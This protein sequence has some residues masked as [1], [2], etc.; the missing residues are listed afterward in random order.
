MTFFRRLLSEDGWSK[1][2]FGPLAIAVGLGAGA[3]VY[4]VANPPTP[5]PPPPPAGSA[6]I[7]VDTS[8]GTC[9]KVTV[10]IDYPN[11]GTEC[12]SLA[13]AYAVAGAG[14]TIGL[15]AGTYSGTTLAYRS[16]LANGSCDPYGEWGA[17]SPTSCV[18][19]VP[20]GGTVIFTGTVTIKGSGIWIDGPLTGSPND[21]SARTYSIV[22]D[23]SADV[24]VSDPMNTGEILTLGD[25]LGH[26]V[27]HVTIQGVHSHNYEI[28][29]SNHVLYT[30]NNAG[31]S[32]RNPLGAGCDRNENTVSTVTI[33][34]GDNVASFDTVANSW[35]HG[36]TET[37]V[38]GGPCHF[39]GTTMNTRGSDI[40]FRR[41]GFTDNVVYDIQFNQNQ[42][43]PRQ[44]IENNYFGCIVATVAGGGAC[45]DT[46]GGSQLSL[47]MQDG[48]Y[49]SWTVRY[50]DFRYPIAMRSSSLTGHFSNATFVGN[51]MAYGAAACTGYGASASQAT[52]DATVNNVWDYNVFI[53][54]SICGTNGR[55]TSPAAVW[56]DGTS[57]VDPNFHLAGGSGSTQADN[58]VP[59][60]VWPIEVDLPGTPRPGSGN[61]DAGPYER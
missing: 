5:P 17:P 43:W 18:K 1:G 4:H 32:S 16:D 44:V 25:T 60:S 12:S 41:N 45:N 33:T 52:K 49:D 8:G 38:P 37:N 19:V 6:N 54:G 42:G 30:D 51:V 59:A 21:F 22:L 20:E 39:G 3:I 46:N 26:A 29:G 10:A 11:D 34:G 27:D 9:A 35:I 61:L 56:V 23:S 36:Q 28:R 50:N 13:G 2:V 58:F 15:E 24:S 40:T 55:T 7:W 47:N 53:N 31:P 57:N 48:A 14:D